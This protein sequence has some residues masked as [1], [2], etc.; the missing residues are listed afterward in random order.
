MS[1]PRSI[2][3]ET[4]AAATAVRH[5]AGWAVVTVDGALDIYTAPALREQLVT[6][7]ERGHGR[8]VVDMDEV[9]FIDSTGLGVLVGALKRIRQTEHGALRV[10]A[11]HDP[12]AH[13]MHMTRLDHVFGPYATVEAAVS[14]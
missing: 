10:V 3:S 6:L 4:V 14:D 8:L 7:I 9:T 12:V 11:T 1:R 5:V 2:V 13:L